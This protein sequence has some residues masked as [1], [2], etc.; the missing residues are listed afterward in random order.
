MVLSF[1]I[2]NKEDINNLKNIINYLSK[3]YNF[4]VSIESN[5]KMLIKVMRMGS[6]NIIKQLINYQ[7]IY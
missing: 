4:P 6:F 1:L 7:I 2:K 3:N 5:I